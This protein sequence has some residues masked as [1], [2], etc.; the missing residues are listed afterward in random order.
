MHILLK[1][2]ADFDTFINGKKFCSITHR[3]AKAL[4]LLTTDAVCAPSL[5]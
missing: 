5:L 4:N 3:H 1:S 2:F